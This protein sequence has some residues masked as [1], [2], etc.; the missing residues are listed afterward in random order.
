MSKDDYLFLESPMPGQVLRRFA[1][2]KEAAKSSEEGDSYDSQLPENPTTFLHEADIITS[3][4]E[5]SDKHKVILDIDFGAQLIPSST[6]G[7]FHLYLDKEVEWSKF[8]TLLSA[9]AKAGIVEH[10]YADASINRGYS[11]VR[12]PWVEKPKKE[13]S[14]ESQDF[15][16]FLGPTDS[17]P[18]TKGMKL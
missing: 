18:F 6:P 10:G 15:A 3:E 9:L 4:I 2:E 13:H 1:T 5:G 12:L 17:V 14:T 16:M 8:K 7:H 11:A